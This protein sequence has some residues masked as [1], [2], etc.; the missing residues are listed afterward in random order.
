MSAHGRTRRRCRDSDAIRATTPAAT[1]ELRLSARHAPWSAGL[2]PLELPTAASRELPARRDLIDIFIG[3]LSRQHL[4][5]GRRCCSQVTQ[6]GCARV[7]RTWPILPRQYASR[8]AEDGACRVRIECGGMG[9]VRVISIAVCLSVCPHVSSCFAV[10]RARA[11][12]KVIFR[13]HALAK[14]N[15]TRQAARHARLSMQIHGPG[16]G[17]PR[18]LHALL[19]EPTAHSLTRDAAGGRSRDAADTAHAH[20]ARKRMHAHTSTRR[21]LTTHAC[22]RACVQRTHVGPPSFA[23][24]CAAGGEAGGG[25]GGR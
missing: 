1:C 23:A 14:L 3:S 8:G 9:S 13:F 18:M 21:R 2:S 5:R 25:S 6:E 11:A 4:M 10:P 15:Q 17:R 16:T 12:T 20:R 7:W 24:S 19:T 22:A